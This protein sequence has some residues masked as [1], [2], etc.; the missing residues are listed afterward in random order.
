MLPFK[1]MEPAPAPQPFDDPAWLFQIKW[2]G[3][4]CLAYI[5]EN[6]RLINR[7]LNPRTDLYPEIIA[8][9]QPMPPGTVLDGE[10]VVLREDGNPSFYKTLKRDLR[11]RPPP[12]LILKSMPAY[13]MVFDMPFYKGANLCHMPL[14]E[15]LITIQQNLPQN[16]VLKMIDTIMQTGIALFAAAEAHGLEGIVA[17]RRDSPYI[18]GTKSPLWLKIKTQNWREN[19]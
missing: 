7:K 6:V 11:T 5:D 8:A 17:K 12:D 19:R 16:S 3:V 14:E 1:P 2:D 10:I 18:I 4:R 13:Y 15:R 9:L